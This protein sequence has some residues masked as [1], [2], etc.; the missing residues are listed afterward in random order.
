MIPGPVLT[1]LGL[2]TA[3]GETPEK[4]WDAL[5][6]GRSISDH[7]RV[8]GLKESHRCAQ[9]AQ[10]AAEQA[11]VHA[12]WSQKI[13]SDERTGLILATSKGPIEDWLTTGPKTAGLSQLT[14]DLARSLK[15]TGPHLTLSAAC[16]TGLHGLIRAAIAI[17]AGEMDR[18]LVVAAEAS[19]HPLFIGS[20]DRLGVLAPPGHGCRPF[21]QTRRGFLMS[22]AAAAITVEPAQ[23][24]MGNP[25]A[26]LDRFALAG[27]AQ[28]LTAGEPDGKTLRHLLHRVAGNQ[29]ID[30][31][32]AHGTG[33]LVHDP[34]ELGAIESITRESITGD[35]KPLL[36]SHK[37]ALGH[38]LG[39]A[40]L[41]AVVI[42][43]LCHQSRAV[44]P[45]PRSAE[46][47]AMKEVEFSGQSINR[48]IDRS[49]AIA[50]GFGGPVAVVSFSK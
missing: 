36:Y 25:I 34:V 5:L 2:I 1:G 29:K 11:I 45:N 46:P 41:V 38:S 3:L 43:C 42:N 15:F 24:P 23:N 4:T 14:A 10:A 37:A 32:H 40:G 48:T 17:A 35:S 50:T 7:A 18:V 22:E 31:I 27:E 13:C 6:A 26:K 12:K 33:T 16:A 20:F 39:A 21:D 49:I 19:V 30:L 44:P 47:L 28:S 8:P 9:L